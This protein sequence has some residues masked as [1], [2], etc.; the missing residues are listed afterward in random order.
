MKKYVLLLLAVLTIAGCSGKNAEETAPPSSSAPS[1]SASAAPPSTPDGTVAP[2][3]SPSEAAPSPEAMG[4]SGWPRLFAFANEDGTRLLT[5][6]GDPE[7]ETGKE[8]A[9]AYVLA[10]GEGGQTVRVRYAGHQKRTELDNG[11]QSAHNFDQS[12]GD[13][14][15]VEG[16][17]AAPDATYALFREGQFDE[18]ALLKLASAE[19]AELPADV[20]ERI[21]KSKDRAIDRGWT[22]A[23][24]EDGL[25]LY[26]VQFERRGDDMLAAVVAEWEGKLAFMDY[27]A[28]YNESSTWR[29]DD[30]GEILPVMF[31]F[32]FAARGEDGLVLGLKWLGAEGE[33]ASILKQKG[34]AFEDTGIG[35]GRYQSPI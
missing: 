34:E 1:P 12:E 4:D 7:G 32:L 16:G 15:E 10:V 23:T 18:G 14:Y 24:G 19:P 30:G 28:T 2:T 13:V 5:I 3:S 8:P 11:R 22:I 21:A 25:R 29:V 35:A 6:Q 26:A 9:E 17:A 31:S 20:A 27:P 33:S